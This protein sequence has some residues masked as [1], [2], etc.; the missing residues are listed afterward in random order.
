MPITVSAAFQTAEEADVNV[1]VA[2]VQL[3]LGDYASADASGAS[4]SSNGDFSAD[5]PAAGAIN[6]DRT[7]INIGPAS[8][9]DNNVGKSSWRSSGIPDS[10][11][12]SQLVIDFG[13]SRT[14][15]RTKLYH[16]NG[17]GLSS[18]L[19][20]YFDGASWIPYA[21]TSDL[22]PA[23]TVGFGQGPFGITPFGNPSP[24]PAP[25]F[26]SFASTLTLD[27]IDHGTLI[28]TKI[29]ITVNHTQ[30]P[31]DFANIV[32]LEVYRLMD[33]TDRIKSVSPNRARDYK[34]NNN[35]VSACTLIADNSDR[36]FSPSYTPTAAEV[37]AGFVNSELRPGLNIFISLGFDFG[38]TTELVRVFTGTIDLFRPKSLAREVDI[39]C[40]DGMK[41]V[42]NQ[43]VSTRL[44][45][46]IDI[47]DAIIYLLNLANISTY[48]SS[49]DTTTIILDY[50]FT[51]EE[52]ILTSIQNLV[53][54]CGDAQFFFDENG[55][56]TFHQ[57]LQNIPQQHVD[58]TQADFVAGTSK[59]NIDTG[60]APGSFKTQW[61]LID[62]FFF[63]AAGFPGPGADPW[64]VDFN[65]NV[66]ITQ[67]GAGAD[68]IAVVLTSTNPTF[69][70]D[71]RRAPFNITTQNAAYGTYRFK[72]T[73]VLTGDGTAI[74]EFIALNGG[75]T[76]VSNAGYSLEFDSANVYLRRRAA[77]GGPSTT[78][79]T[80]GA[81]DGLEHEW[82][83]TRETNGTFN[84]YKDGSAV[85]LGT[86]V[87]LAI[88]NNQCIIFGINGTAG[89]GVSTIKAVWWSNDFLPTAAL[90]RNAPADPYP[91]K[92]IFQSQVIDQQSS[93][94]AE[95]NIIVNIDIPATTSVAIYTATSADGSSFD[96][97]V[98]AGSSGAGGTLTYAIGSTTRRYIKYKIEF[99][100]RNTN[101][102]GAGN[103]FLTDGRTPTVFDV[104]IT[105]STTAGSSKYHVTP[106]F[107]L[108]YDGSIQSIEEEIADSLGGD[109]AIINDVSV[110]SSPLIL[111]GT[112]A[113]TQWQ[114]TANTPAA[115]VSAGNPYSVAI[116]TYTFDCIVPSGMDTSLMSGANPAAAVVT[117]GG[118]AAGSW[119]I[120]KAHPTKPTLVITITVGGTITDLR[121]VG[122]SFQ[123]S[124]T[125]YQ[126]SSS[127]AASIAKYA[128]RTQAI[129]NGFIINPGIA[130]AIAA[131]LVSNF[132]DPVTYLPGMEV[133]P[134]YR[135]QLGDRATVI[136]D[137]TGLSNDFNVV[138]IVHALAGQPN[139]AE[140]KMTVTLIKIPPGS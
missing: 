34:L 53:Q 29:R 124:G 61:F 104:T 132:K 109:T 139:G 58:T 43:I 15:N 40:R 94:L 38:G 35:L 65:A 75:F 101:S 80:V 119:V 99:T 81:N 6:G 64:V 36:F 45:T 72:Y 74:V 103:I 123:A 131:R 73:A 89:S 27:T 134:H 71:L 46:A 25:V 39:D 32:A 44:K 22:Y 128:R 30:V 31:N 92:P 3:V 115:A 98:L 93:I 20:E 135:M 116:G 60:S 12:G 108:R 105:W 83:I 117:F 63:V 137:N 5:Y 76:G 14:F 21:G 127:D 17:H 41:D 37:A 1:P 67:P 78:L 126:A 23:G 24:S 121:L 114:G 66:T 82:R 33:V 18:F 129:T 50:F 122:K 138:G 42:L 59:Q 110:A 100:I 136:D 133:R 28:G 79:L 26:Q 84:V 57:Y 91:L 88:T 120:S 125:P 2:K 86:V 96:P 102:G 11:A 56:A 106:D 49:I 4:V 9:A 97:Y 113:D 8:G 87:D 48:E 112:N 85:S 68:G 47:K 130:A 10:A 118:G 13:Q 90:P 95:G 19:L 107:T 140:A 55:I 16:V 69:R 77:G 51:F 111:E 54:A 52:S 7:E 70:A 62:D